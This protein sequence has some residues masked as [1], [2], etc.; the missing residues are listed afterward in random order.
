MNL[1]DT[2]DG[3]EIDD[4]VRV[5]EVPG[6]SSGSSALLIRNGDSVAAV[7]GD[8]LPNT[9]AVGSGMP[10]LVFG[11]PN[12]AAQSIRK[13][14][15]NATVFYPG[16]DRPFEVGDA[17]KTRYLEPANIRVFGWPDPGEDEGVG[18]LAFSIDA[19]RGASVVQG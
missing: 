1:Q 15:D 2:R 6:H 14:L 5:L 7:C 10:R 17:R 4:G 3:E 9:W 16:H 13:L 8:A 12:D 18:G 19:S 11:D